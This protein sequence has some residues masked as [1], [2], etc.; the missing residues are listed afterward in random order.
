[1]K[2]TAHTKGHYGIEDPE[3]K[4]SKKGEQEDSDKWD[5][6]PKKHKSAKMAWERGTN[7]YF[8]LP[9]ATILWC[10]SYQLPEDK[11]NNETHPLASTKLSGLEKSWF[12]LS[13]IGLL[14]MIKGTHFCCL[15]DPDS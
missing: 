13:Q 11:G 15:R 12:P 14:S 9:C 4:F 8:C 7:E 10:P 2:Y 6:S 5:K 3:L 1:M